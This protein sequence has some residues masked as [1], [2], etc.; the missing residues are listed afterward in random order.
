MWLPD[1]FFARTST[2]PDNST[3]QRDVT[4]RFPDW[5]QWS[6]GAGTTL[7]PCHPK[8]PQ[9]P[10]AAKR[11]GDQFRN[12][13]MAWRERSASPDTPLIPVRKPAGDVPLGGGVVRPG[14]GP[15]EEPV[16]QPHRDART[17]ARARTAA[18]ADVRG[19]VPSASVSRGRTRSYR[20]IADA[21]V[22]GWGPDGAVPL[23]TKMRRPSNSMVS[24]SGILRWWW[25][26][27]TRT[28]GWWWCDPRSPPATAERLLAR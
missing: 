24:R 27:P 19:R 2:G 18:E 11:P 8:V 21:G 10:T 28:P 7:T 14:A 22:D 15:C 1:R 6:V 5:D 17:S 3:T 16:G 26:R 23:M 9:L 13:R 4:S 25:C 12:L 20:S